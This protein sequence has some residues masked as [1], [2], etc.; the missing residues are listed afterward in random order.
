MARFGSNSKLSQVSHPLHQKRGSGYKTGHKTNLPCAGS[1]QGHYSSWPSS[2]APLINSV[3]A[4][5][6][7]YYMSNIL[8]TKKFLVNLTAIIRKFWW[9]GVQEGSNTNFLCL[10]SWEEI[11]L[12]GKKGDLRIKNIQATN[13]SLICSD[14]WRLAQ[15]PNS[16]LAL[17]LKAKY[18][19]GTTIWKASKAVPKSTFWASILKRQ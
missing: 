9:T 2:S 6:P 18:H 3:F 16:M 15:E 8:F 10:K 7:I 1:Q 4:S 11:C 19:R 12:P 14:A 13:T 5:I 17:V